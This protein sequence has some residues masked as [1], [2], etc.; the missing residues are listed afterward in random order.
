MLYEGKTNYAK[1]QTNKHGFE[2]L[3][4]LCVMWPKL[5]G[6]SSSAICIM[7]DR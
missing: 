1:F 3:L 4:S 5:Q 6:G 7:K 2:L